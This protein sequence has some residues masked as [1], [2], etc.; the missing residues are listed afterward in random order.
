MSEVWCQKELSQV[1]VSEALMGVHK[2]MIVVTD[3]MH[4]THRRDK[5]NHKV[6]ISKCLAKQDQ[7]FFLNGTGM[8]ADPNESL[9]EEA[10]R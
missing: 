2:Q 5:W 7:H 10:R 9:A 8:R 6:G 1:R 4:Q 3:K